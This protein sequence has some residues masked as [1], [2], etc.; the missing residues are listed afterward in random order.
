VING[1]YLS[2]ILTCGSLSMLYAV[3]KDDRPLPIGCGQ[4]ISAPHMHAHVLEELLPPLEERFRRNDPIKILDVGIGSGYLTS[5][6][7]R[8]LEVLHIKD[9]TRKIV[10][11][12]V[13]GIEYVTQLLDVSK[14]NTNKFDK[15]LLENGLVDLQHGDGWRGLPDASP[16]H[17][18][19][20]GA[21]AVTFPKNLMKQLA[22]GGVMIIP[23]GAQE[24][25]QVLYKVKRISLSTASSFCEEDFKIEKLLNVRYVPLV[26][27][28]MKP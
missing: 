28:D 16:F 27:G 1:R 13:W 3:I 21:A 15:D 24:S 9:G 23:V 12:K 18:I 14:E 8:F 7:G 5:C 6:F 20:V 17:A 11:S 22:V 2:Y 10:D 25:V 4:T 26:R 19:H